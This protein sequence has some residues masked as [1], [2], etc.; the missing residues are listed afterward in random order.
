MIVEKILYWLFSGSKPAALQNRNAPEPDSTDDSDSESVYRERKPGEPPTLRTAV[1][2]NRST[3][4][5]RMPQVK[6]LAGAVVADAKAAASD[7]GEM[8]S[9]V[10]DSITGAADKLTKPVTAAKKVVATTGKNIQNESRKLKQAATVELGWENPVKRMVRNNRVIT[11]CAIAI[12]LFA[13]GGYAWSNRPTRF[14]R[15]DAIDIQPETQRET[16]SF[17]EL[18]D[19]PVYEGVKETLKSDDRPR[20]RTASNRTPANVSIPTFQ[21][22][23]SN[24]QFDPFDALDDTE[25][26]DTTPTNQFDTAPTQAVQSP[27]ESFEDAEFEPTQPETP[28][29]SNGPS[30]GNDTAAPLLKIGFEGR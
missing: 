25:T 24:S 27:F 12:G 6:K 2:S 4:M 3:P 9:D 23:E 21:Q 19:L 7:V 29:L 8:A 30:L 16:D 26:V 22:P 18:L 10:K 28:G 14:V 5:S 13:F 11:A 20:L 1:L 15:K 17:D